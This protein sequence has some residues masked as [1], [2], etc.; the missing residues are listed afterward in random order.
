MQTPVKFSARPVQPLY[1]PTDR[2]TVQ[3]ICYQ[4]PA[5]L[6][7]D[8]IPFLPQKELLWRNISMMLL[9]VGYH[10]TGRG[11]LLLC[12]EE[13]WRSLALH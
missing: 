13:G 1:H 8:F 11:W 5:L 3:L 9:T 2:M 4:V 12:G 10:V 7:G 6:E